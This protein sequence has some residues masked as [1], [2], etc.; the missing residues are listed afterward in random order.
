MQFV[1]ADEAVG[2]VKLAQGRELGSLK[3]LAKYG[4]SA[5]FRPGGGERVGERGGVTER[6]DNVN[7]RKIKVILYLL[8]EL[9]PP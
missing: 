4:C 8:P 9:S 1:R 3:A 6:L 2:V 7:S 5:P